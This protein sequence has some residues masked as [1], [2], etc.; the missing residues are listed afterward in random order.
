MVMEETW[1]G[2][3]GVK[4]GGGDPVNAALGWMGVEGAREGWGGGDLALRGTWRCGSLRNRACETVKAE[5]ALSWTSKHRLLI[6]S[7]P[8]P[9]PAL[10]APPT[11]PP[12]PQPGYFCHHGC[13]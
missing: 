13:R 9:P 11:L 10:T 12:P 1:R 2:A 6:T 3:T 5:E 7:V 8:S 4:E